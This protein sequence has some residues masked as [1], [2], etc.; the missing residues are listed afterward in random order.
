MYFFTICLEVT[1]FTEEDRVHVHRIALITFFLCGIDGLGLIDISAIGI[2]VCL[3]HFGRTRR[4]TWTYV[5][6]IGLY[7]GYH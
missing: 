3:R 2:S 1:T 5:G 7:A 4:I 6:S